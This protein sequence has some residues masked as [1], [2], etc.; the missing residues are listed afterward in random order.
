MRI[1]A[2]VTNSSSAHHVSL[3][4]D[5]VAHP[6]VVPPRAPGQGSSVNGGELLFLALATCYCNDI[7]REAGKRGLTVTRVEVGVDGEFGNPGEPARNITY[8]ARVTG[9]AGEEELRELM[10]ATDKVAEIQNTLRL[11]TPVTLVDMEPVSEHA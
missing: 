2:R 7:Y 5:G 4:T 1:S 6:L 8:R 10:L 11:G 3:E 9:P